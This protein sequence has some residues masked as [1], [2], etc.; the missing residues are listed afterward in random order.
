MITY[1]A[2][3]ANRLKSCYHSSYQLQVFI[4]WLM[5]LLPRDFQIKL[6]QNGVSV[7]DELP[8]SNLGY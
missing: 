4:Y 5:Y 6:V 3:K 8:W 1:L 7:N 2:L